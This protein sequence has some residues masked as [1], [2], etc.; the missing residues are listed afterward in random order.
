MSNAFFR[1]KQFTIHQ[2]YCAMKV[3]TDSCL[4][5]AWLDAGNSHVKINALEIGTGTGLLS[6]MLAQRFPHMELDAVEID[7]SAAAQAAAN[8]ATSPW[9][10]RLKVFHTDILQFQTFKKYDFIFSNPPFFQKSLK[11]PEKNINL[12][13]HDDGLAYFQLLQIIHEKLLP[14]GSFAV[15]LPFENKDHFIEDAKNFHFYL[16]SELWIKHRQKHP[17]FRVFLHFSRE[18]VEPG[19]QTME[20]YKDD[21]TYSRAFRDL[22]EDYYLYL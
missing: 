10:E 7:A 22:L 9:T 3:C 1:F 8:M 20:I 18:D 6:L 21:H 13:R 12:A 2:E 19:K 5:G 14:G 4:F 16:Q 11:S 17:W 15:L